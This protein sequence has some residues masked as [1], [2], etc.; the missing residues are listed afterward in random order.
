MLCS[1][2]RKSALHHGCQQPLRSPASPDPPSHPPLGPCRGS[3]DME[4][5]NRQRVNPRRSPG[6][7]GLDDLARQF[8]TP[9]RRFRAIKLF[10]SQ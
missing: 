6:L 5:C 4:R 7:C 2:D 3:S 8:P 1:L 10:V 9:N